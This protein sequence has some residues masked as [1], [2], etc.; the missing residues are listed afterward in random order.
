MFLKPIACNAINETRFSR[1]TNLKILLLTCGLKHNTIFSVQPHRRILIASTRRRE[2]SNV[3]A[4]VRSQKKTWAWH[5]PMT[6][7]QTNNITLTDV[8]MDGFLHSFIHSC[9]DNENSQ[10]STSNKTAA[11]C[12]CHST[13]S[14]C[15]EFPVENPLFLQDKCH[16]Y[17]TTAVVAT[18][19]IASIIFEQ[20]QQQ[21]Q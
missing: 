21:Q 19:L 18:I 3:C 7:N 1:R 11:C 8:W 20:Q 4:W 2:R 9:L 13:S 12:N 16:Y 15:F 17:E 14:C 5:L 6:Q 10:Y